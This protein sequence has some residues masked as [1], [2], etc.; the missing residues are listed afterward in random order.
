MK[1]YISSILIP[2]LLLQLLGCYSYRAI[3]LD[4]LKQYRGANNIR[5]VK[6]TTEIIINRKMDIY[7]QMNWNTTDSSLLINKKT[8]KNYA[9][10]SLVENEKMEIPY[11]KISATEIE[12]IDYVKTTIFSVALTVVVVFAV[13]GLLVSQNG[14]DIGLHG[15]W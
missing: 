2:C 6:D 13:T 1:R 7:E 5:V 14:L 8:I 9:D 10:S 3:T 15:N 12:E 11:S 4:E